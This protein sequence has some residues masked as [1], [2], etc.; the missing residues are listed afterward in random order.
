MHNAVQVVGLAG[1]YVGL[2]VL[3]FT[4]TK[5]DEKFGMFEVLTTAFR[6]TTQL[7]HINIRF[8]A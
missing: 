5:L 7:L 4:T 1:D 2:V 8:I 6:I 3:P